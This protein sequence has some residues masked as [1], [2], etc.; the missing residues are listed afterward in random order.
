MDT[1][2]R[3]EALLTEPQLRVA[4][5]CDSDV[6]LSVVVLERILV[7]GGTSKLFFEEGTETPQLP[8][9]GSSISTSV[10]RQE[11]QFAQTEVSEPGI[12]VE[13][14]LEPMDLNRAEPLTTQVTQMKQAMSERHRDRSRLDDRL[15]DGNGLS[16]RPSDGL[17][18]NCVTVSRYSL[19]Q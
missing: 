9:A 3:D 11:V 19:W 10:M 15:S 13:F 8:F 6:E 7:L 16:D 12:V 4:T 14:V 18:R 2:T 5:L 1:T 17:R